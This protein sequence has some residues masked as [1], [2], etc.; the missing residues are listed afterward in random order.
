MVSHEVFNKGIDRLRRLF[1]PRTWD[2]DLQAEYFNTCS[3]LSDEEFQAAVQ[4]AIDKQ[5]FMPKP[6]VLLKYGNRHRERQRQEQQEQKANLADCDMCDR[7]YIYC[8]RYARETDDGGRVVQKEITG[9][10]ACTCEAGEYVQ[11]ARA[12][13]KSWP[14]ARALYHLDGEPYNGRDKVT[15]R[16]LGERDPSDPPF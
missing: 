15:G 12:G 14:E 13:V 3:K 4:R 10:V 2:N 5:K 9:Y 11:T 7:G 16:L 8:C 6:S 1:N